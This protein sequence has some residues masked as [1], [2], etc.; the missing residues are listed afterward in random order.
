MP[1]TLEKASAAPVPAAAE[2]T[3]FRLALFGAVLVVTLFAGYGLGRLTSGPAG[4]EAA[5]G[6]SGRAG[7]AGGSAQGGPSGGFG[8]AG[9]PGMPM[10]V[11]ESRPHTHGPAPAVNGMGSV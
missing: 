6:A 9:M 10:P 8:Q 3:G 7:P 2:R 11:D 1:D 5:A 4:R